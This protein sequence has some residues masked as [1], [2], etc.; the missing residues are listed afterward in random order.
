MR[1]SKVSMSRLIRRHSIGLRIERKNSF[2][3]RFEAESH[4]NVKCNSA[5][6]I[7]RQFLSAIQ[8]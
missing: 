6:R 7:S 2:G 8:P 4:S 3:C 5:K 1:F